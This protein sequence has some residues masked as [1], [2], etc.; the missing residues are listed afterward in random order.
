[1]EPIRPEIIAKNINESKNTFE[2]SST[3]QD[4]SKNQKALQ[5]TA[6]EL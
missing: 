2:L 6:K 5:N 4:F 1:M 3:G